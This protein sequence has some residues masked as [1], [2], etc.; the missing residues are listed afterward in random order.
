MKNK[1]AYAQYGQG[2]RGP[3]LTVGVP[4]KEDKKGYKVFVQSKWRR[5]R[6]GDVLDYVLIDDEKV[7]I[8]ISKD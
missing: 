8:L 2:T 7:N 6:S 4:L 5:V 3:F 1:N